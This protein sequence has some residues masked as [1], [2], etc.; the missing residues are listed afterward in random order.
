MNRVTMVAALNGVTTMPH[1]AAPRTA[2]RSF[3]WIAILI[4]AMGLAISAM[5]L[6]ACD[7]EIFGPDTPTTHSSV[8]GV[9][10]SAADGS[11]IEGAKLYPAPTGWVIT[12]GRRLVSDTAVTDAAGRYALD[13]EHYCSATV[14][15]EADG[16]LVVYRGLDLSCLGTAGTVVFD[17]VL[18]PSD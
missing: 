9:V 3:C 8:R 16:Y 7:L 1:W 17:I 12:S 11:P 5:G 15:A 4:S 13:T 2:L 14:A 18:E 10:T 6:A